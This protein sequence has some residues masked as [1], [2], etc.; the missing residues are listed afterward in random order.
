MTDVCVEHRI[1]FGLLGAPVGHI[2]LG[3]A[4]G[5]GPPAP[6]PMTG[7]AGN[8][9]GSIDA[10]TLRSLSHQKHISVLHLSKNDIVNCPVVQFLTRN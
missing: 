5:S 3:H 1:Q 2:E 10:S 8:A 6:N 7:T 4:G 9:V